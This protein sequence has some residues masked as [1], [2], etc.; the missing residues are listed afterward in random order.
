MTTDTLTD[1]AAPATEA[2]S[3]AGL[4]FGDSSPA[5]APAAAAP[6]DAELSSAPADADQAAEQPA[7][8]EYEPF[9][10]PEGVTTDEDVLGEF[11]GIAKE[12]KLSQ[13]DA[14]RLADVGIKM[15]Q[16]Q[17]EAYRQTQTQWIESSKSDKEFGGVA[18]Q[19]NL[20]IARKAMEAFATPELRDLLN[21]TGFGNHPELIRHFV[22]VGKAISED[23]RVVSGTKAAVPSDP[24]KRLFPNQA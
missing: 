16:K 18:L 4:M 9:V 12:L 2:P 11:K 14:Q 15:Q 8:V 22:R 19:E 10:V 5:T 23:G 13:T 24:A 17:A 21:Q 20:G 6:A 3:Q 1:G 7:A